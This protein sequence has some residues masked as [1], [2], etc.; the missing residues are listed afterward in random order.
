MESSDAEDTLREA[1]SNDDR[2]ALAAE[3]SEHLRGKARQVYADFTEVLRN[4][5]IARP[6]TSLAIAAG[7]GL[8]LGALRVA[9]SRTR[10]DARARTNR[11][12]STRPRFAIARR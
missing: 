3:R 4:A 6:L 12:Y 7:I 10:N 5:T 9:T 11:R 2:A 8:V 1:A